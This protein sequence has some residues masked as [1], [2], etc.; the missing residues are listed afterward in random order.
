MRTFLVVFCSL[1]LACA[2]GGAQEGKGTT[3]DHAIN[4]GELAQSKS[5]QFARPT[6]DALAP[7]QPLVASIK[8]QRIKE[9]KPQTIKEVASMLKELMRY[10]FFFPLLLFLHIPVAPTVLGVCLVVIALLFPSSALPEASKGRVKLP[11]GINV[12]FQGGLRLAA[13]IAGIV[14]I[15]SG[16]IEAGKGYAKDYRRDYHP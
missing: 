13:I 7:L 8:P 9:I 12:S 11:G 1:A 16:M 6:D 3:S 10:G 5:T 15:A 2:A 14:L 4:L